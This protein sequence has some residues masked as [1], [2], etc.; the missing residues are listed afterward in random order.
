[1]SNSRNSRTLRKLSLGSTFVLSIALLSGLLFAL[2]AHPADVT[3]A[4]GSPVR[5]VAQSPAGNDTGNNC[6]NSATPCASVQH[7]VDVANTDDYIKVAA[8]TYT[9][10]QSRAGITQVVYLSKTVTIRGGYTTTNWTVS[11]PKTNPV[12]LDAEGQGRALYVTG[13]TTPMIEGLSLTGG[14]AIGLGGAPS[15]STGGGVLVA[16]ASPTFRN[17]YIFNNDAAFGGGLAAYQ[18][19]KLMLINNIISEN[20]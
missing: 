8:G 10:I 20:E 19:S 16:G 3:L 17:N 7:A 18:S 13:N 5:Y 6:S 9:G 11:D 14:N 2:A 15:G 1:M 4:Q 12:T